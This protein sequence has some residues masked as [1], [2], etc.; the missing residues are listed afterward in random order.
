M[1]AACIAQRLRRVRGVVRDSWHVLRAGMVT[2]RSRSRFCPETVTDAPSV[3]PVEAFG[4]DFTAWAGSFAVPLSLVRC[5]RDTDTA[6]A[7]STPTP[8][9][10]IARFCHLSASPWRVVFHVRTSCGS[11]YAN[12]RLSFQAPEHGS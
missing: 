8:H 2:W 1:K 4:T 12:T 6:S 10:D 11:G 3:F 7:R 9:G 5:F